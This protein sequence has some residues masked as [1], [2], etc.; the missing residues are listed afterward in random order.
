MK[1]TVEERENSSL[2]L[3]SCV[4]VQID[5]RSAVDFPYFLRLRGPSEHILRLGGGR[6][7]IAIPEDDQLGCSHSRKMIDGAKLVRRETQPGPHHRSQRG[8]CGRTEWADVHA[9]PVG[10]RVPDRSE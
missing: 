3:L 10:G 8:R 4:P 9:E 1:A 2:V 5:V 7:T 6:A